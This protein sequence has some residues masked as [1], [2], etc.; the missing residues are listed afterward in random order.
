[1]KRFSIILVLAVSVI[2]FMSGTSM[3]LTLGDNGVEDTLQ[4]VFDKSITVGDDGLNDIDAEN[5]QS[6]IGAWS[7]SEGNIDAYLITM[8]KGDS[9]VLGIY[10]TS[11]GAE[12]DLMVDTQYQTSFGIN[13]SGALWFGDDEID[14][15]FG[16]TFGFYWK[17]TSEPLMS[18]TQDSK[19]A[20]GTGYG[21]T[22]TLGL[23]YLVTEGHQVKTQYMGGTTVNATGN[24]DWILAFEDRPVDDPNWADGDFNDAVFYMEDMEAVPEPSTVLLLGF[25]L[26]GLVGFKMKKNKK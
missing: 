2:F 10:S 19:N 16:D 3:A 25:G 18:Y 8:L 11:T 21:D 13:D 5:D 6:G 26:L 14:T 17:N 4:E 24:N 12:Y 20:S 1:M 9:G 23:S 15:T 7:K 22:N